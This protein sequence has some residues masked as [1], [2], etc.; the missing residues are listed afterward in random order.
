[1]FYWIACVLIRIIFLLTMRVRTKGLAAARRSGGYLLACS[2][3]SHLDPFC[4]GGMFPAKNRLDGAHRILPP[5]LGGRS[6]G[7]GACFSGASAGRSSPGDS[8]GSRAAE[9]GRSSGHVSG[10]RNQSGERSRSFAEVRSS[11]EFVFS[12]RVPACPVL[13]CII[14]GTEKLNHVAPWLP[15]LR[16]RLWIVCGEFIE[17]VTGR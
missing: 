16:G 10:G 11:A 7:P 13:P 9:A 15:F 17:P 5:A 1:M 2:H 8:D 4:L 14:L 12:P 6:D 3:V